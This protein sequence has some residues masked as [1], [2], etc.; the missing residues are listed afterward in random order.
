MMAM[1]NIHL[2]D[3]IKELDKP[4]SFFG[5][6]AYTCYRCKDFVRDM[7]YNLH[8]KKIKQLCWLIKFWWKYFNWDFHY[9]LELMLWSTNDLIQNYKNNDI[10]EGQEKD[11]MELEDFRD[12]LKYFVDNDIKSVDEYDRHMSIFISKFVNMRKWWL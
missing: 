8:W 7:Y 5:S 2:E 9:S 10:Y 1:K 6:I 11:L 3:L 12:S 4:R